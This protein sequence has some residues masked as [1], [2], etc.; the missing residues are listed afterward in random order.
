MYKK[1]AGANF[2]LIPQKRDGLRVFK[3]FQPC[4]AAYPRLKVVEDFQRKNQ[5]KSLRDNTQR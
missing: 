4:Y 5:I 1:L 3:K 2:C